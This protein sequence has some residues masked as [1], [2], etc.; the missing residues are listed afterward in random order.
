MVESTS[1]TVSNRELISRIYNDVHAALWAALITFVLWFVLTVAP[2]F[3]EASRQAQIERIIEVTHENSLYCEK[4]RMPPGSREHD[5]C[6]LDVQAF[7]AAVERRIIAE[8]SF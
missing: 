2:H 6:M 1:G 5:R 7:R 8:N 4:F 3:P